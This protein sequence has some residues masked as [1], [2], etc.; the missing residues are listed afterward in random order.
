M[1]FSSDYMQVTAIENDYLEEHKGESAPS[2]QNEADSNINADDTPTVDEDNDD[3]ENNEDYEEYEGLGDENQYRNIMLLSAEEPE[4]DEDCFTIKANGQDINAQNHVSFKYDEGITFDIELTDSAPAS[5]NIKSKTIMIKPENE[6]FYTLRNTSDVILDPGVYYLS[7]IVDV[8]TVIANSNSSKYRIEI[9][10][11]KLNDVSNVAWENATFKTKATW[12]TISNSYLEGY[13]LKLYKG[14]TKDTAQ[15]KETILL[16]DDISEY[17]FSEKME[18]Y[19]YGKYLYSVKAISKDERYYKNADEVWSDTALTKDIIPPVIESYTAD[20]NGFAAIAKDHESGLVQYA[21]SKEQDESKVTW[22]SIPTGQ[23]NNATLQFDFATKC[24]DTSASGI[25]Y[26]YVKDKDGNVTKAEPSHQVTVIKLNKIYYSDRNAKNQSKTIYYADNIPLA[27]PTDMVRNGYNFAGWYDNDNSGNEE[28]NKNGIFAGTKYE[29]VTHSLTGLQLWAIWVPRDINVES[30]SS[31]VT[32]VYDGKPITLK[33]AVTQMN[34][35]QYQ[36]YKGTEPI[37]GA[38]TTQLTLNGDVNASGVYKCKI[39]IAGETK[40]TTTTKEIV[41]AVSKRPITIKALS[42]ECAYGEMPTYQYEFEGL[43]QGTQITIPTADQNFQCTYQK[44]SPVGT[45][46]ITPPTYTDNNYQVTSINGSLRVVPKEVEQDNLNGIRVLIK[47]GAEQ[48]ENYSTTYMGAPIRPEVVLEDT[49]VSTTLKAGIDYSVGYSN[50]VSAGTAT[51]TISFAGNYH[52]TITKNFEII[53]E[54]MT[55]QVNM[56]GWT[57][58]NTANTPS[59]TANPGKARVT[60]YYYGENETK[61]DATLQRPKNAGNYYVFAT[62]DESE[63]YD[64]FETGAKA[65]TIQKRKITIHSPSGT[66]VYNGQ[67]FSMP[68]YTMEGNVVDPDKISVSVN[69][70]I[71]DVTSP[72]GVTNTITYRISESNV[73]A[74]KTNYDVTL[75]EGILRVT[76]KQ[77]NVPSNRKWNTTNYG[78]AVWYGVSQT[79]VDVDY[80]VSLYKKGNPTP[81]ET[82]TTQNTAY[83]FSGKIKEQGAGAT[84]YYKVKA[85]PVGGAKKDNYTESAE[86]ESNDLLTTLVTVSCGSGIEYVKI[87]ETLLHNNETYMM[88]QGETLPITVSIQDGYETGNPVW[89]CV[90]D[91]IS[92]SETKEQNS[93]ITATV[94]NTQTATLKALVK[95]SLPEILDYTASYELNTDYQKAIFSLHAIDGTGITHWKISTDETIEQAKKSSWETCTETNKNDVTITKVISITDLAADEMK[96]YAWVKDRDENI[97]KYPVSISVYKIKIESGLVGCSGSMPKYLLKLENVNITLPAMG[98]SKEG[99][100]FQNW[101]GTSGYYNNESIYRVN[102]ADTLTGH[103]TQIKYEYIVKYFYQ[104]TDGTYDTKEDL[105]KNFFGYYGDMI[106]V[107][108]A[109][110]QI[111][112]G[113]GFAK[114]TTKTNEGTQKITL[115]NDAAGTPTLSLYYSRNQYKITFELTKPDNKKESTDKSFFYEESIVEEVPATIPGYVF[116]GWTYEGSATP[117][118]MPNKNLKATGKYL[119]ADIRYH[120]AYWEQTLEDENTYTLVETVDRTAHTGEN[121]ILSKLKNIEREGFTP[122]YY[123]VTKG[124][125]G[126]ATPDSTKKSIAGSVEIPLTPDYEGDQAKDVNINIYY[127]RNSYKITLE[128]WEKSRTNKIVSKDFSLKYGALLDSNEETYTAV[129]TSTIAEKEAQGYELAPTAS[130][131]TETKPERMPAGDI[132]VSRDFI[133]KNQALYVINVYLENVTPNEYEK[134]GEFTYSAIENSTVTIGENVTDTKTYAEILEQ[135]YNHEQYEIDTVKTNSAA[136]SGVVT[137]DTKLSFDV[138]YKRKVKT[139][140]IHYCYYDESHI[141]HEIATVKKKGRWG[142]TYHIEP[143]LLYFDISQSIYYES[144]DA[145]KQIDASYNTS[146]INFYN[147]KYTISYRTSYQVDK[148]TSTTSKSINTFAQYTTCDADAI[149][150]FGK[151]DSNNQSFVYYTPQK[152]VAD[153]REPDLEFVEIPVKIFDTNNL[154]NANDQ[155]V[156]KQFNGEE[157][158]FYIASKAQ[159]FKLEMHAGETQTLSDYPWSVH[160]SSGFQCTNELRDGYTKVKVE[161]NTM[162]ELQ[163]DAAEYDFI[164]KKADK[165]IYLLENTNQLYAGRYAYIATASI[166]N[167]IYTDKIVQDM[168]D[169][170]KAGSDDP[171]IL[172][173]KTYGLYINGEVKS[174]LFGRYHIYYDSDDKKIT[175]SLKETDGSVKTHEHEVPRYTTLDIPCEHERTYFQ[176]KAGYDLKWYKDQSYQTPATSIKINDNMTI[177]GRYEKKTLNNSIFT[178]YGLENPIT[179]GGNEYEYVTKENVQAFISANKVTK[180]DAGT[181]VLKYATKEENVETP[182][183][184]LVQTYHY[185]MNDTI[186]MIEQIAPSSSFS[187]ISIK[188]DDFEKSGYIFDETSTNNS[189]YRYIQADKVDLSIFFKRIQYSVTWDFDGAD[190]KPNKEKEIYSYDQQVT[191]EAPVKKGYDFEGWKWTC[192]DSTTGRYLNYDEKWEASKRPDYDADNKV[193]IYVPKDNLFAKATWKPKDLTQHVVTFYQTTDLSYKNDLYNQLKASTENVTVKAYTLTFEGKMLKAG[194]TI[195]GVKIPYLY[196]GVQVYAYFDNPEKLADGSVSVRQ[197]NLIAYECEYPVTVGDEKTVKDWF[198]AGDDKYY[199]FSHVVVSDEKETHRYTNSEDTFSIKADQKIEYYR[200]KLSNYRIR[201]IVR[202]TTADKSISETVLNYTQNIPEKMFGEQMTLDI[203]PKDGYRVKGWYRASESLNG[204]DPMNVPENLNGFLLKDEL[205]EALQVG[206]NQ[207]DFTVTVPLDIVVVIEPEEAVKGNVTVSIDGEKRYVYGYE[208]GKKI[209]ATWNIDARESQNLTANYQWYEVVDGIK[210]PLTGEIA[211]EYTLPLG[212]EQGVYH[213]TCGIKLRNNNNGEVSEEFFP[214]QDCEIIVDG[215]ELQASAHGVYTTYDGLSHQIELTVESPVRASEYQIYYSDTTAL[216]L[217]NYD[218]V[219]TTTKL[220]YKDVKMNEAINVVTDR[221]IYY[222]IHSKNKNYTDTYGEAKIRINRAPVVLVAKNPIT[223]EY[224]G[225]DQLPLGTDIFADDHAILSGVYTLDR[226]K[227]KLNYTAVF[228]SAHVEKAEKVEV[229]CQ[230][231]NGKPTYFKDAEG[232]PNYNYDLK[233]P[234]LSIPATITPFVLDIDWTFDGSGEEKNQHGIYDGVILDENKD[235][236]MENNTFIYYFNARKHVP[237]P[238]VTETC[239][240]RIPD[241]VAKDKML[242]SMATQVKVYAGIYNAYAT[243]SGDGY[244]ASDYEIP[245]S[246]QIQKF[247]VKK[248]PVIVQPCKKYK[249]AVGEWVFD[250]D[251]EVEYDGKP[252]SYSETEFVV[253]DTIMPEHMV[254]TVNDLMLALAAFHVK[255]DGTVC[256]MDKEVTEASSEPYTISAVSLKAI[257]LDIDMT[258]NFDITY[259]SAKLTIKPAVLKI[260]GIKVNDKTY[261]A[262]TKATLDTSEVTFTRVET[263]LSDS[264]DFTSLVTDDRL[265]LNA[266]ALE[267]HFADAN[268][269]NNKNVTIATKGALTEFSYV[270][271]NDATVSGKIAEPDLLHGKGAGNYVVLWEK[272][273][274]TAVSQ[275]AAKGNIK[276]AK[277]LLSVGN[278]FGNDTVT[279]V[280]YG[281]KPEIIPHYQGFVQKPDGSYEDETDLGNPTITVSFMDGDNYG[282]Q[283]DP[284]VDLLKDNVILL[285]PAVRTYSLGLSVVNSQWDSLNY[286]VD[287]VDGLTCAVKPCPITIIPKADVHPMKVYDATLS[288]KSVFD[289][290]QNKYVDLFGLTDGVYEFACD[291]QTDLANL[292]IDPASDYSALYETQNASAHN[293]ITVSGLK[294]KDAVNQR[295]SFYE[296]VNDTF[297]LDGVIEKNILMIR[298][299]PRDNSSYASIHFTYGDRVYNERLVDSSDW[300]IGTTSSKVPNEYKT[301]KYLVN[302]GSVLSFVSE[303]ETKDILKRL[304]TLRYDWDKMIREN[305]GSIKAR[306]TYYNPP[307]EDGRGIIPIAEAEICKDVGKYYYYITGDVE[308]DN[309]EVK[310]EDVKRDFYVFP[311]IIKLGVENIEKAYLDEL[312]VDDFKYIIPN[313]NDTSVWKYA[314]DYEEYTEIIKTKDLKY[315]VS[316]NDNTLLTA[317]MLSSQLNYTGSN[318]L[319]PGTYVITPSMEGLRARYGKSDTNNNVSMDSGS[320]PKKSDGSFYNYY[321]SKYVEPATLNVHQLYLKIDPS[322]ITV[323]DKVYDGNKNITKNL[324]DGKNGNE[325]ATSIDTSQIRFEAYTDEACTNR[326]TGSVG[327]HGLPAN[328]ES[329]VG[330][331]WNQLSVTAT[332]DNKDVAVDATGNVIDKTVSLTFALENDL[333]K[334]Y[335]LM[336]TTGVNHAKIKP[337]KVTIGV[338]NVAAGSNLNTIPYG[339][340][341]AE[342]YNKFFDWLTFTGEGGNTPFAKGETTVTLRLKENMTY[343]TGTECHETE[344]HFGDVEYQDTGT[345]VMEPRLKQTWLNHNY[346]VTYTKGQVTITPAQFLPSIPKW[347]S[348][349]P[350]TINW[351]VPD[352]S[353][354]GNIGI[355]AYEVCLGNLYGTKPVSGTN[356][357]MEAWVRVDATTGNIIAESSEAAVIPMEAQKQGNVYSVNLAELVR[358]LNVGSAF[359]VWIRVIPST[360]HNEHMKNVMETTHDNALNLQSDYIYTKK[361]NLDYE[362]YN[363]R[364]QKQTKNGEITSYYIGAKSDVSSHYLISGEKIDFHAVMKNATGYEIIGFTSSVVKIDAAKGNMEITGEGDD[365]VATYTNEIS[366]PT[367]S[368]D[369]KPVNVVIKVGKRKPTVKIKVTVPEDKKNITYGYTQE[370]APTFKAIV[371]PEDTDT[372]SAEQYTYEYTWQCI[373]SVTQG[374]SY[375]V[376]VADMNKLNTDQDNEC[377]LP[378][379]YSKL[380]NM[381]IVCFVTATRNDNGETITIGNK[382]EVGSLKFNFMDCFT[383]TQ[384]A[385]YTSCTTTININWV[386]NLDIEVQLEGWKY[387]EARK[388]PVCPKSSAGNYEQNPEQLQITYQYTKDGEENWITKDI[389][390]TDAGIYQ[391]RAVRPDGYNYKGG[392]SQNPVTFTIAKAKLET[393]SNL[394]MLPSDTAP[395]GKASWDVVPGIKENNGTDSKSESTVKY[396]VELQYSENGTTWTTQKTYPQQTDNTLDM[397]SDMNK[398]AIYRYSVKAISSNADNCENSEIAMSQEVDIRGLIT[399]NDAVKNPFSKT[400]DGDALE[401]KVTFTNVTVQSYQWYCNGAAISGA[402]TDTYN[403]VTYVSGVSDQSSGIYTCQITDEHG[404]TAY[405]NFQT[406]EITKKPVTI[407]ALGNTKVFDATALSRNEVSYTSL[408]TNDTLTATLKQNAITNAGEI[409]NEFETRVDSILTGKEDVKIEHTRVGGTNLDVTHCY[410]ITIK[411]EKLTVTP[412]SLTDTD[413][414]VE[415]IPNEE[416]TGLNHEPVITV[417]HASSGHASDTI[418]HTYIDGTQKENLHITYADHLHAGTATVTITGKNNYTGTITKNFTITKKALRITSLGKQRGYQKGV[419]LKFTDNVVT[420]QLTVTGLIND[421]YISKVKFTGSQLNV[422]SSPNTFEGITISHATNGNVTNDYDFSGANITYGTLEVIKAQDPLLKLNNNI[423]TLDKTYDGNPVSIQASDYVIE[424]PGEVTISYKKVDGTSLAGAPVHAGTYKITITEATSDNYLET[425]DTREFTIAKRPITIKADDQ[426][427]VYLTAKKNLTYKVTSGSIVEADKT[428]MNVQVT[429]ADVTVDNTTDNRINCNVGS[430]DINVTSD[431]PGN[432]YQITYTKGTY[433]VTKATIAYTSGSYTGVYDGAEHQISVN[434]TNP[435]D[436]TIY[437]S[438]I[439][440]LTAANYTNASVSS[441]TNPKYMHVK[442]DSDNNYEGAYKVYYYIYKPNYE[443]VKGFETVNIT[444]KAQDIN[445]TSTMNLTYDGSN[446]QIIGQATEDISARISYKQIQIIRNGRVVANENVEQTRYAAVDAGTYKVKILAGET[447]NYKPAS[448]D[449]TLVINKRPLRIAAASDRKEYDKTPLTNSNTL[450]PEGLAVMSMDNIANITMQG[451]QTQVGSSENKITSIVIKNSAGKD[452][453]DNYDITKLPGTL[454]VL[455]ATPTIRAYTLESDGSKTYETAKVSAALSKDYDET[456]IVT[457]QFEFDGESPVLLTYYQKNNSGN[458]VTIAG[459]PKNAGNYKVVASAVESHNYVEATPVE[460]LF[461]ISK[462]LDPI[463]V[464]NTITTLDKEYDGTVVS[465]G[466]SHFTRK[467][468]GNIKITYLDE[469]KNRLSG[470][471]TNKGTYTL[472]NHAPTAAG[473]YFV[474]IE[475]SECM[476]YLT[477]TTDRAFTITKRQAKIISE[478]KN[479]TYADVMKPL[480][481]KTE[482]ILDADLAGFAISVSTLATSTSTAGQDYDITITFTDNPNYQIEKVEGKYTINFAKIKADITV[483]TVIYDGNAHSINITP[484]IPADAD[485]YYSTVGALTEDNLTDVSLNV[486]KVSP[487]FTNAGTYTIYYCIKRD[488]YTSV[489]DSKVLIINKSTQ[490][491]SLDDTTLL[492]TTSADGKSQEHVYDGENHGI[493][494]K[495]SALASENVQLEYANNEEVDAGTYEVSVTAPETTNYKR[496]TA[497]FTMQITKRP[498]EITAQSASKVYDRVTLTKNAYDITSGNLVQT[499]IME[500]I[501]TVTYVGS[502]T[503]VG[504]STNKITKVVIKNAADKDVTDNYDI[505]LIDGSLTVSIAPASITIQNDATYFNKTYDKQRCRMPNYTYSGDGSAIIEFY[506]NA[507]GNWSTTAPSNAG[508]YKVRARAEATLNYTACQ[509]NEVAFTIAK[510]QIMVESTSVVGKYGHLPEKFTVTTSGNIYPGDDLDIKVV[511]PAG[512]TAASP[513]GTYTLDISYVQNNNYEVHLTRGTYTIIPADMHYTVA[514]YY[515]EYDGKDHGI[516]MHIDDEAREQYKVYYSTK[517]ALND[518]NYD[519]EGSL[520]PPSYKDAGR[521]TVYYYINT[522]DNYHKVEGVSSIFIREKTLTIRPD[523]TTICYGDEITQNAMRYEGF[524]TGEYI[525]QLSGQLDFDTEYTQYAPRGYYAVTPKGVTA[526]NYQVIFQMGEIEVV[527][528]PVA[529]IWSANQIVYTGEEQQVTA[530]VANTVQDDEFEVGGYEGNIATEIGDYE[531]EALSIIVADGNAADIYNYTLQGAENVKHTW[532]IVKEIIIPPVPSDEPNDNTINRPEPVVEEENKLLSLLEIIPEEVIDNEEKPTEIITPVPDLEFKPKE[533]DQQIDTTPQREK[534]INKQEEEERIIAEDEI[535][536]I[537]DEPSIDRGGPEHEYAIVND[538]KMTEERQCYNHTTI[539]V[540]GASYVVVV[541]LVPTRKRKRWRNKSIAIFCLLLGIQLYGGHCEYDI[542][543]TIAS[544]IAGSA[545]EKIKYLIMKHK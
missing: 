346:D 279:E 511:Y 485:V 118:T 213:Y 157:Y 41:V 509:S 173:I 197:D 390:P 526:R 493:I 264:I 494:A 239:K 198:N 164:I 400:Y 301:G 126:S 285:D 63:N 284:N 222:Y 4:V 95:D 468:D 15:L 300:T 110:I 507:T 234:Q 90:G 207:Y 153:G 187:E 484:K 89:N 543:V 97:V 233:V 470:S 433:T 80:E 5:T 392:V 66:R 461:T 388:S 33:V 502:Q 341:K 452:V 445:V 533:D 54:S 499:P 236:E 368:I 492:M 223:K 342:A 179:I 491:I 230:T 209:R 271:E 116:S 327:T 39:S 480:T 138:Y 536:P 387:G 166:G 27:L 21:F 335:K 24:T 11:N 288:A 325:Q 472:M 308:A 430:Y 219:G 111:D 67:N 427:S 527:K 122:E 38:T 521:Y 35:L 151:T 332:Y 328:D 329:G 184:E 14:D 417:K 381:Q 456:V 406:I 150:N 211:E 224:D 466:M 143:R 512:L 420:D 523:D 214:E 254:N 134:K 363:S 377:T 434:V 302:Q 269:A 443:P 248:R 350:G 415:D 276:K 181:T 437:Y 289:E 259:E 412:K 481:Y 378:I 243:L 88:F 188:K 169:A 312:S 495:T 18:E 70:S 440:E 200:N 114:D 152:E 176:T 112:A 334:K 450:N 25:Y 107:E 339:T 314:G 520:I 58:G 538:L 295:E 2:D 508:S 449:V 537:P 147:G 464:Q 297:T 22:E 10:S 366:L 263:K 333:A 199:G 338:R 320:M 316:N 84:Y 399:V 68:T 163:N 303:S 83:D 396:E 395:Y 432:D 206:L 185:K 130:W 510:E 61:A 519:T 125:T 246:S 361:V 382:A 148:T 421:D 498:L 444:K 194:D 322:S 146:P 398:K 448:K 349:K 467:G 171:K 411:V 506:D 352:I 545:A 371:T 483:P 513:V 160:F 453:T 482:R 385:Y 13:Q 281:H 170:K 1:T 231:V 100:R 358:S 514:D 77:L 175:Y 296:L 55:A 51:I 139:A 235:P 204:Y 438:D 42:T 168:I 158:S 113:S 64:A 471:A 154:I 227:A 103:W 193:T 344:S 96:Y 535:P 429:A 455:P 291:V 48:V 32:K 30:Q 532:H 129:A 518:S 8:N 379:N 180:E 81:I 486:T 44:G 123:V 115:G 474:R 9:T 503:N 225:N 65:F 31:N 299:K 255:T 73:E 515:G 203:T 127:T 87:G 109:S 237:L 354:I 410:D 99:Y 265:E 489:C 195:L 241:S 407:T 424:G 29:R 391:V 326:Y 386:A 460:V 256:K 270:A 408:A 319:L 321:I 57:Y 174:G 531:A 459:K 473:N 306:G 476:N 120:L 345:Y 226:E 177:Y 426:T 364:N 135:F 93:E 283:L 310:Y 34:G 446:H 376:A 36:W 92:V 372:V 309:Y 257:L 215:V 347:D 121:Y 182:H 324:Y 228:D 47:N 132:V 451:S 370:E 128:V 355:A 500:R 205:G 428:A 353:T 274:G 487:E 167:H 50:N 529:F 268:T 210:R 186:V 397:T 315:T 365:K 217:S 541:V 60:Y 496:A 357:S 409:A 20:Q 3:N 249:N 124:E 413:I 242:V 12:N 418:P 105:S 244:T 286:S 6:S 280:V 389:P 190:D 318:T 457:P 383:G 220:S 311:V 542:P 293:E 539:F 441:T 19:G 394:Q 106:T 136:L 442:V 401:M 475:E 37:A 40:V 380:N 49:K 165:K 94:S 208:Q 343:L 260:E 72:E 238:T 375:S 348:T 517:I 435:V 155:V 465:F 104:K 275:H 405:S 82:A 218:T 26:F 356:A 183:N 191:K 305:D 196:G 133:E 251:I 317:D 140:I 425:S 216:D 336:T 403:L 330:E 221:T 359:R 423:A 240:D 384:S 101:Q 172:G 98:Y 490:T 469:N 292:M 53:K 447:R 524:V 212:K 201:F 337:R 232:N 149:G 462:V 454:T 253:K 351:K 23:G 75:D 544:F 402:T 137:R 62:I 91:C 501:D 202:N 86:G 436:A 119:A 189:L 161:D 369:T 272:E 52:G 258:D 422:G 516:E 178:S 273:D 28:E 277:L 367:G 247:E 528:R 497:K 278:V 360:T 250:T 262:D 431:N 530:V 419:P 102:R 478:S 323:P 362:V 74:G 404:K 298:L 439:A 85:I 43:P 266:D 458:Y 229:I 331:C 56:T 287:F 505:T 261:D 488:N 373:H 340:T 477:T 141:C 540:L 117:L 393:P 71:I 159:V 7:F 108:N 142:E 313:K 145:Q 46:N 252:H 267:A 245:I 504:V 144:A 294:L 304:D 78:L 69:T 522:S 156:K 463:Q 282:P 17:D 307:G 131:S 59:I 374:G 76:A 416:Y 16:E 290:A 192:Y 45:Y 479:S 162:T 414:S 534:V 79:G 525:E